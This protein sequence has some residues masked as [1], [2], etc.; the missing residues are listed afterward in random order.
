MSAWSVLSAAP[1][2]RSPDVLQHWRAECS[3]CYGTTWRSRRTSTAVRGQV[4]AHAGRPPPT[5]SGCCP[6]HKSRKAAH[7]SNRHTSAGHAGPEASELHSTRCR[8]RACL[9]ATAPLPACHTSCN[10]QVQVHIPGP[11]RLKHSRILENNRVCRL[12]LTAHGAHGVR[13]SHDQQ[14]VRSARMVAACLSKTSRDHD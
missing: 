1:V 12:I 5:C 2:R 13:T 9:K 3:T 7:T 4:V 11:C 10:A 6:R 8:D 14:Q